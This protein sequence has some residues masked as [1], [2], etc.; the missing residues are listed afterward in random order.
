M[1]SKPEVSEVAESQGWSGI[2]SN[3]W[4]PAQVTLK[5][6]RTYFNMSDILCEMS[7]SWRTS[8]ISLLIQMTWIICGFRSWCLGNTD[9][10]H[11][12]AGT[13]VHKGPFYMPCT[14]TYKHIVY[15][16][17]HMLLIDI[18]IHRCIHRHIHRYIHRYIDTDI[19]T[20]I[21]IYIYTYIPTYL[22]TYIHTYIHT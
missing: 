15:I 8:L 13:L 7:C 19:H 20:Y 2:S 3:V 1:C 11:V 17:I 10:S 4:C 21:Y 5:R 6:W 9:C 16:Y 12:G 22:H 14:C 18:H